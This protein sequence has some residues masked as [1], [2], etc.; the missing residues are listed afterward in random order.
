MC[1]GGPRGQFANVDGVTDE[2]GVKGES[3][4]A[5]HDDSAHE[6]RGTLG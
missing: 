1:P 4:V 3:P 5:Y 6:K 2:A